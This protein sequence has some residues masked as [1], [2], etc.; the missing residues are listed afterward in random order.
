M[1]IRS[2]TRVSWVLVPPLV[3]LAA[4]RN[5]AKKAPLGDA[6]VGP[7]SVQIRS[8]TTPQSAVVATIKHGDHVEIIDQRRRSLLVRTSNGAEGW[9]EDRQLLAPPDM[10]ALKQLSARS[11]QMP[12]QGIATTYADLR[13]HSQPSYLAPSF[14]VLKANDKFDVLE[15]I[16][17]PRTEAAR[18]PLIPPPPKKVKTDRKAPQKNLKL[19]PPPMPRPPGLP[20]NWLEL[21]KSTLPPKQELT[22]PDAHA[23]KPVPAD[24]WSLIRTPAGESGWV[25]SRLI[26]PAIPDEVAQYAEGHRIVSYF[27]LGDVQNGDQKKTIWLWT[28]IGRCV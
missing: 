15:Q 1:R 7:L 2:I 17:T 20:P 18:T 28:T 22:P 11:A 12:T 19:L 13:V 10:A 23:E 14:L 8:D 25:Y 9:T 16:V 4:C 21:S 26:T 24:R 5:G 27:P 3:F 6:Y